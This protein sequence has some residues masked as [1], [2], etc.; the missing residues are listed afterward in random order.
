M[1]CIGAVAVSARTPGTSV[2]LNSTD[3]YGPTDTHITTTARCGS[4][5][6][7]HR[8]FIPSCV[9]EKPAISVRSASR[10]DSLKQPGK[11]EPLPYFAVGLALKHHIHLHG[12][13]GT[14]MLRANLC[15][16]PPRPPRLALPASSLSIPSQIIRDVYIR[17]KNIENRTRSRK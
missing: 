7:H 1:I 6:C 5:S 14:C 13:N 16:C 2:K 4:D 15:S 8:V 17:K 3:L 10:Q 11:D 9:L 12:K